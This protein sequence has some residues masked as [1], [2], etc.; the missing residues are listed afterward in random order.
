VSVGSAND[1]LGAPDRL[2]HSQGDAVTRWE[3]VLSAYA[4][5]IAAH[6]DVLYGLDAD[7]SGLGPD[8]MIDSISTLVLPDDMPPMPA[9]LLAW[10]QALERE[11]QN[12][13]DLAAKYLASNRPMASARIGRGQADS[14][15]TLD[16][17]M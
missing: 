6:S 10:A 7:A 11:T 14:V 12:L 8:D 1:L 2:A 13:I 4:A 15:S 9:S 3:T 16:R 5:S 17:K